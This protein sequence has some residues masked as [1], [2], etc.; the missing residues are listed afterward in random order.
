LR[1]GFKK[2]GFALLASCLMTAA[3]PVYAQDNSN[4]VPE[5][6]VDGSV[7][8]TLDPSGGKTMPPIKLV[9][10]PSMKNEAVMAHM[11]YPALEEAEIP[12]QEI[13]TPIPANIP[14]IEIST[15]PEPVAVAETKP[16]A[17]IIS[18][19]EI[20]NAKPETVGNM[21]AGKISK[22]IDLAKD[23]ARPTNRSKIAPVTNVT[24]TE[25]SVGELL[26]PEPPPVAALKSTTLPKAEIAPV[27]DIVDITKPPLTMTETANL[28]AP[29]E[30]PVVFPIKTTTKIKG[31]M[32]PSALA[33][34]TIPTAPTELRA[35]INKALPVPTE[36]DDSDKQGHP[37]VLY[38]DV[39]LPRP[40]PAV[41]M[42]S[43]EFVKQARRTYEDTYTVV[44]RDGDRMPAV[45]K[46]RVAVEALPPSRLSVADIASDPLA[47]QLVEMSPNDIAD[48]LNKIA[49]AAGSNERQQEEVVRS[50]HVRIVR[51]TGNWGQKKNSRAAPAVSPEPPILPPA[52]RPIPEVANITSKQETSSSL[53]KKAMQGRYTINFKAGETDL[54][55]TSFNEVDSGI[56]SALK[57]DNTARV[58]IVAYASAEGGKDSDARRASLSR[59]LSIRSYLISKGINATR[60]DVHAMGIEQDAKTTSDKV[61]MILILAKKS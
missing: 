60:M 36:R 24:Q 30:K 32:N 21:K 42:A 26:T 52:V 4:P 56:I 6:E 10:T 54:P 47:S 20:L 38:K 51:E 59:A 22:P 34:A 55:T 19:E 37:E 25:T 5:V 48:T 43:M 46:E 29:V 18:A 49:P 17:P 14:P 3:I 50:T 27:T 2:T 53:P 35:D 45:K 16:A 40:R 31:E 7:L 1:Q 12:V 41:A 15:V 28:K 58:E 11:P 57:S 9:P 23:N 13:K 39:P 33:T 61:D 44:K 8:Q